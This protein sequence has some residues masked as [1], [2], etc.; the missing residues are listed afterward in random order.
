MKLLAETG[1]PLLQTLLS[2]TCWSCKPVADAVIPTVS[3]EGNR[4]E[5]LPH[6]KGQTQGVTFVLCGHN[7]LEVRVGDTSF[8]TRNL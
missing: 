3:R 4:G 6:P 5:G 8:N 2:N 1:L 7:Q